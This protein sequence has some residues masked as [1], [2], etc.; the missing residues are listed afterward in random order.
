MFGFR[1][2]SFYTL[3]LAG[4][5]GG[6]GTLPVSAQENSAA[7]GKGNEMPYMFEEIR[8][9]EGLV[10]EGRV[11]KPQVQFPLLKEAPPLPEIQFEAGFRQQLL[12]LERENTFHR[13]E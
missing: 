11:E 10:V 4:W 13:G 12:D 5:L 9:E 7:G 2:F 1:I 3:A 8:F 6:I